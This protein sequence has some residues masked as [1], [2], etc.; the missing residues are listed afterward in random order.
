VRAH[1]IHLKRPEILAPNAHVAQLAE[2]GVHAVYGAV[3]GED[4]FDHPTSRLHAHGDALGDADLLP[5][6]RRTH[7][8]EGQ[9]VS[10]DGDHSSPDAT[11]MLAPV[12]S[13][14][15]PSPL[16]S[17]SLDL[18]CCTQRHSECSARTTHR[19]NRRA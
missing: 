12:P 6:R 8:L 18:S 3:G 10:V 1:E 19:T 13:F 5:E 9:R 17:R 14:V 11:S 16:Q 4:L 15:L 7:L 2:A